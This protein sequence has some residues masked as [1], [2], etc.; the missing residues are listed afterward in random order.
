MTIFS[1]QPFSSKQTIHWHTY[2]KL[3]VRSNTVMNINYTYLVP[4]KAFWQWQHQLHESKHFHST[5]T[6]LWSKIV[7]TEPR[8]YIDYYSHESIVMHEILPRVN[9]FHLHK[10]SKEAVWVVYG[11]S[12]A[13]ELWSMCFTQ[14]YSQHMIFP[15]SNTYPETVK[16]IIESRIKL[17]VNSFLYLTERLLCSER[18]IW[19]A[20]V[21]KV[22]L[23]LE[24]SWV[25]R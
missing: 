21:I 6:S 14:S 24:H 22:L 18:V 9:I 8:L 11:L 19:E 1:P 13:I 25:R 20:L 3:I 16:N 10:W 7:T 15:F 12:W 5:S 17:Q 23:K 4:L 2:T